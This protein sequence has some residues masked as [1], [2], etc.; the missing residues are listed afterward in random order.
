MSSSKEMIELLE[1]FISFRTIAGANDQKRHCLEWVRD[2]F[3]ERMSPN[4]VRTNES[5]D[6][7]G[8]S[9][10]S[11]SGVRSRKVILDDIDG[12]PYLFLPHTKSRGIYRNCHQQLVI[13]V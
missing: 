13:S 9:L 10:D 11:P 7:L 8:P 2:T 1:T 6:H 12:T 4:S 5:R 3:L